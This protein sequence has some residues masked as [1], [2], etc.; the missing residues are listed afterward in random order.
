MKPLNAENP[1]CN[2]ISSNCVIW[3]G[4]D[5]PCIKLCKGDTISD[6]VYKLAVELCAIMDQLA[7]SNYDLSCLNLGTATPTDIKGLIQLLVEKICA[8]INVDPATTS[9][10]TSNVQVPIASCFYFNNQFGDQVTTMTLQD[11][12]TTI[13]NTICNMI[14][15]LGL[16]QSVIATHTQQITALQD[17]QNSQVQNNTPVLISPT[18][19]LPPEPSLVETVVVALEQQFCIL[20]GAVGT[21]NEIYL[22]I[23]KQCAGLAQ[24]PALGGGG[25]TMGSI[26]GWQGSVTNLASSLNNLWLTIC[27]IREAITNIQVN[28]C[29]TACSGILMNLQGVVVGTNA[30]IYVTGTIPAG[31]LTCNPLGTLITVSDSEG[32]SYTTFFNI[33][34]SIN[35]PTGYTIPLAGT[36]VNPASNITITIQACLTNASTSATCQSVL[37]TVIINSAICPAMTYDTT[38]GSITYTGT[39]QAGIATYTLELW[40]NSGMT[41]LSNKVQLLNGPAIL[42]GTF[43]TL[44]PATN[45]KLRVKVTVNGIDTF[46]PFTVVSTLSAVCPPPSSVSATII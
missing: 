21:A 31:F 39:V 23:S 18:C 27:D 2:P 10:S 14:Q 30:T 42:T 25:G 45:Y 17:F 29:P 41:M 1:G 5:I 34:T 44:D 4:N 24:A 3:Q 19:V 7:I 22:A 37:Q 11:Y 32:G 33:V 6:V 13:G 15:Q 43:L 35:N 16:D 20:L 28:C 46:C 26:P 9:S 36:P 8:L 38:Q 40:N 12:V